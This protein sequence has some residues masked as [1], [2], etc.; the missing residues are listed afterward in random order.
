MP[1]H[2]NTI[3]AEYIKPQGKEDRNPFAILSIARDVL[4]LVAFGLSVMAFVRVGQLE[5]AGVED[6]MLRC[7]ATGHRTEVPLIFE[8]SVTKS[9]RNVTKVKSETYILDPDAGI[10]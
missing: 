7:I 5:C 6:G 3:M 1:I 4:I 8:T 2:K 10:H 9:I